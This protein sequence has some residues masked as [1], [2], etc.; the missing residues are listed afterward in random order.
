MHP[1]TVTVLVVFLIIVLFYQKIRELKENNDNLAQQIR[2][3][4]AK[5]KADSSKQSET[6]H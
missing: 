4:E 1:C 5:E 6:V 2:A 3:Y